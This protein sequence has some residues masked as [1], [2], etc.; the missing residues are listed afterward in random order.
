VLICLPYVTETET[1]DGYTMKCVTWPAKCQT[2]SYFHSD[3]ACVNLTEL[4]SSFLAPNRSNSRQERHLD[5]KI[6]IV[7]FWPLPKAAEFSSVWTK[8]GLTSYH[9]VGGEIIWSPSMAVLLSVDLRLSADESAVSNLWWLAVA[10]LQAASVPIA[11]GS[12]T[13]RAAVPSDREKDRQ[14]DRSQYRLMPPLRHGH[15]K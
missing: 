4:S 13:P 14:T 15:N 1:L 5:K 2:C 12:C 9:P 7:K 10:K 3:T 6:V 8:S 11:Q